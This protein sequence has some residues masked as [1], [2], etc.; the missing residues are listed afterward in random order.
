MINIIDIKRYNEICCF[1]NCEQIEWGKIVPKVLKLRNLS[2]D[3]FL[4]RWNENVSLKPW[5][6]KMGKKD[7]KYSLKWLIFFI[8]RCLSRSHQIFE[9]AYETQNQMKAIQLLKM[10]RW[11]N[12]RYV[13]DFC[14]PSIRNWKS[15][16]RHNHFCRRKLIGF[17]LFWLLYNCN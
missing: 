15:S 5:Q 4:I 14:E 1:W 16:V 3:V 6:N 9:R 8:F 17:K 12:Q 10:V 2:L 11:Q 13:G 7:C